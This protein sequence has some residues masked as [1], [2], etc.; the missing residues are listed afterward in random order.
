LV[1]ICKYA[2]GNA[3][4]DRHLT[5]AIASNTID[6][7]VNLQTNITVPDAAIC[8]AI[9]TKPP[10]L[11]PTFPPG[12]PVPTLAPGPPSTAT[13]PPTLAGPANNGTQPPD[14]C[15]WA[16][17]A[18]P[19][20]GKG[21]GKGYDS[22]RTKSKKSRHHGKKKSSS[23]KVAKGSKG[24]EY[25]EDVFTEDYTT[26]DD[27]NS[28]HYDSSHGDWYWCPPGYGDE[29]TM[30]PSWPKGSSGKHY[31]PTGG[32]Y[33]PRPMQKHS[34]PTHSPPIT[35]GSDEESDT[36]SSTSNATDGTIYPQ[37][38]QPVNTY[39]A[40]PPASSGSSGTE[41]SPGTTSGGYGGDGYNYAAPYMPGGGGAYSSSHPDSPVTGVGAS[42][43]QGY[44]PPTVNTFGGGMTA[45]SSS[46]TS[47]SPTMAI[48]I[49]AVAGGSVLV[50]V[51]GFVVR[52]KLVDGDEDDDG[53]SRGDKAVLE[54][55][56]GDH[57]VST[58]SH[59]GNIMNGIGNGGSGGAGI[60]GSGGGPPMQ[61]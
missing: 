20:S 51:I 30:A 13:S 17:P 39:W 44:A 2:R 14:G 4:P 8:P 23:V 24:A 10:T 15:Y 16:G 50:L 42:N 18:Y 38:D 43:T 45:S 60:I 53:H 59:T 21:K 54:T 25:V 40:I 33:N 41:T 36:G 32:N 37:N 35:I 55:Q 49:A 5:S 28:Y 1:R 52:R 34:A 12:V 31:K 6:S 19:K 26:Q 29:G 57:S 9:Y 22:P 46:S 48:L 47:S 27:D 58:I 7:I 11:S 56:S 61:V 3:V